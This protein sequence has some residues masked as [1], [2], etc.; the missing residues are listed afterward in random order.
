MMSGLLLSVTVP[1]LDA[2]LIDHAVHAIESGLLSDSEVLDMLT[3][4]LVRRTTME[5][6]AV[7]AK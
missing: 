1:P 7:N 3:D 5:V 2:S 4:D 6:I